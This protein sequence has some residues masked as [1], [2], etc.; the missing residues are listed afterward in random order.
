V[1]GALW[2]GYA[3]AKSGFH[4][5]QDLSWVGFDTG[6]DAAI[7]VVADH[8]GGGIPLARE[9]IDPGEQCA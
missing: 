9:V 5:G 7:V 4:I 6:D 2:D 8:L 1:R 3:T